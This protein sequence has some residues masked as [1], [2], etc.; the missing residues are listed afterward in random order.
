MNTIYILLIFW[1]P[2]P[3][4]ASAVVEFDS[5]AACTATAV[6]FH[7]QHKKAAYMGDQLIIMC[8]KK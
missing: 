2:S 7:R 1:S 3:G 4:T 5:L 8:A 6:E